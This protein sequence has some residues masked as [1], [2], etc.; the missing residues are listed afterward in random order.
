LVIRTEGWV[1]GL[2]LA[3]L[4]LQGHADPA[5]FVQT[6]TGSHRDILDYLTEEVPAR[7]PE[8]LVRFLLETSVLE[9]LSG[10]CAT[11]SAG[12]ATARGCWSSS[13][14]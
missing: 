8:E 9:R 3:A 2:Q 11:S 12:G 4:S 5:G 6:F 14:G 13:S 7:Q 1:A 10:R